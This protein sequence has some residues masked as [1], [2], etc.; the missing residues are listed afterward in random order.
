MHPCG[1]RK[2]R[3]FLCEAWHVQIA[4]T[5]RAWVAENRDEPTDCKTDGFVCRAQSPC[6]S[7]T[8]CYVGARRLTVGMQS[9][10]PTM[11]PSPSPVY[12]DIPFGEWSPPPVSWKTSITSVCEVTSEGIG[13]FII[14]WHGV[15]LYGVHRTCRNIN[16][17]TWHQPCHTISTPLWWVLKKKAL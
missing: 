5:V 8:D 11:T 17:F 14:R 7:V 12:V 2:V 13:V 16:S 1:D 9:R 10:W 6:C 4:L 15:W 3:W